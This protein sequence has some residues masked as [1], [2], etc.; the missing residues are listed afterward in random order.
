MNQLSTIRTMRTHVIIFLALIIVQFWLGMTINLELTLHA[1]NSGGMTA[2]VFYAMHYWPVL[3]HMLIGITI[4]VVSLSFTI[5]SFR[6]HSRALIVI[7]IVGL[8]A[9]IGAIYNGIE[10]LLSN[11]FFGN[12][13]GMAM[14]AVSAIVIYAVALYYIGSISS[15]SATP[16]I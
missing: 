10:F 8:V 12:S 4:L 5:Q 11:Q 16:R 6:S 14:S 7:G 2:L 1:P 13:I 15:E 9:V 3:V